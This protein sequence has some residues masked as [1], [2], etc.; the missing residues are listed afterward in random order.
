MVDILC[1]AQSVRRCYGT[2]QMIGA[3]VPPGRLQ[4]QLVADGDGRVVRELLALVDGLGARQ[5]GQRRGGQVVHDATKNPRN[6]VSLRRFPGRRCQAQQTGPSTTIVRRLAAN[7]R[8]VQRI[9]STFI[10]SR[11]GWDVAH[12]TISLFATKPPGIDAA[13]HGVLQGTVGSHEEGC[14]YA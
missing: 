7:V 2:N 10:E 9:K 3:G 5:P 11:G 1:I 14:R 12:S 6:L 4:R 8:A 13:V